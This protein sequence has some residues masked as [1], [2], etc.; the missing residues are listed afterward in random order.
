M[1]T[2]PTTTGIVVFDGAEELDWA[3]PWEVFASGRRDGDRVVTISVEPGPLTCAKGLRILADH[4]IDDHPPL[5]VV[6][7]PGGRGTRPLAV[8]ERFLGWLRAVDASST[9]TTSVCTGAFCLAGAGLLEGRRAT[10]HWAHT[11]KLAD[12]GPVGEVVTGRR[13]VRDGK[14]VTAAGVSAGIDMALWLLGQIAGV[15]HARTTQHYI[16]YD[17]APPYTAE[18]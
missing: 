13:Y 4:T 7:V 17:P 3:G 14:V 11:D 6:L 2:T 9:W 15:E 5:D 18:V 10:T 12:W 8:D 16:E 1:T